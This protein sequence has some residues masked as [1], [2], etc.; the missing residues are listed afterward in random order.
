MVLQVNNSARSPVSPSDQLERALQSLSV[1]RVS[2]ADVIAL[3]LDSTLYLPQ[4]AAAAL[5]PEDEARGRISLGVYQLE[6]FN[7]VPAFSSIEALAS[8]V[9]PGTPY[10]ALASKALFQMWAEDWLAINP[11]SRYAL[12]FA[13]SEV[14]ALAAGELPNSVE[15]RIADRETH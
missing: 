2:V 9:K 1:T 7:F 5:T 11:V 4:H 6:G 13:P 12:I 14:S 8:F 3:L 15:I 10:A